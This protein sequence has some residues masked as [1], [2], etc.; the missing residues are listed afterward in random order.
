MKAILGRTVK[1]G[2]VLVIGTR[3][4]KRPGMREMLAPT[5]TLMGMGMGTRSP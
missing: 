3:A 4:W 2:T 1:A 5:A